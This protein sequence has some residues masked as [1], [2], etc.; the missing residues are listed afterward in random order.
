MNETIIE[1]SDDKRCNFVNAIAIQTDSSSRINCITVFVQFPGSI[2]GWISF[3]GR[4]LE[5][6]EEQSTD[7]EHLLTNTQILAVKRLSDLAYEDNFLDDYLDLN[8]EIV[9]ELMQ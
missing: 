2:G 7:C 1:L 6:I 8:K 9:E 4:E 3:K 5:T